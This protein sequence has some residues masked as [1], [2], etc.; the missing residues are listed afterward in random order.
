MYFP[1]ALTLPGPDRTDPFPGPLSVMGVQARRIQRAPRPGSLRSKRP[2]SLG[3]LGRVLSAAR[4]S[5]SGVSPI[6]LGGKRC[7]RGPSRA[8]G[9]KTE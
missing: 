8:A 9:R 3:R 5:R 2:G 6:P 1:L 4:P 7:W